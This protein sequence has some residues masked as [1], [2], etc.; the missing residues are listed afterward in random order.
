M[1]KQKNFGRNLYFCAKFNF[2][3]KIFFSW[4]NF[5]IFSKNGYFWPNVRFWSK[6]MLKLFFKKL[7]EKKLE[8]KY[9]IFSY[10]KKL[11]L[12][13]QKLYS[14]Y[15]IKFMY[16]QKQ[17]LRKSKC[18]NILKTVYPTWKSNRLKFSSYDYFIACFSVHIWR[19]LRPLLRSQ[20]YNTIY[21]DV[22]MW[23]KVR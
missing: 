23:Y 5:F 17:I 4:L 3:P 16:K 19:N 11:I 21:D 14:I 22:K 6:H 8:S 18:Q 12:I 9:Q 10:I 13:K 20:L 2:L 15:D 7:V 1:Y